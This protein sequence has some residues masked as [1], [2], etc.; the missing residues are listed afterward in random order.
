MGSS[1]FHGF[2]YKPLTNKLL[3][4]V[5]RRNRR[6]C[7]SAYSIPIMA[8]EPEGGKLRL[9]SDRSQ[10][11]SDC[12]PPQLSRKGR[13]ARHPFAGQFL[14]APPSKSVQNLSPP[15]LLPSRRVRACS[16]LSAAVLSPRPSRSPWSAL[17]RGAASQLSYNAP[18]CARSAG[19]PGPVT[20][21]QPRALLASAPAL[22]SPRSPLP[23]CFLR[24]LPRGCESPVLLRRRLLLLPAALVTAA[25][26][27]LCGSGRFCA[28]SVRRAARSCPPRRRWSRAEGSRRAGRT[29]PYG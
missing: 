3:V 11:K 4:Y 20:P 16:S 27:S 7:A 9:R 18:R 23:R 6:F 22:P 17:H 12:L 25:R 5:S 26:S 28:G 1:S 10:Q 8:S 21:S 24:S 14:L 2:I 15:G 29:A 19:G 13:V